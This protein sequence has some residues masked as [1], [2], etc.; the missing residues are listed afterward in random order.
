MGMDIKQIQDLIKFVSKSGVNEVAIEEKDFKITIKTNQEPTYVTASVPV[1]AA[2]VAP[3]PAAVAPAAVPVA[4]SEE[5]NFITIKSPMIGTFYRSAGPGKPSF[6][7]AGDEI[8]TGN[9]LCIIE[10]M[11]LFNE[12]ESEVSGKIVKILVEDAQPVE[13]DQPLFLVDPR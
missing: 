13:F 4:V 1:A 9:V 2:P 7:N 12:I 6:V 3:Q 5:S 10:A 11:K 8:N